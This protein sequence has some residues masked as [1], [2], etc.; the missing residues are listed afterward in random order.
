MSLNNLINELKNEA[1][2]EIVSLEKESSLRLQEIDQKGEQEVN[3]L[4]KEKEEDFSLEKKKTLD[5]YLK[6][7]EFQAQMDLLELK[8]KI[9]E[10]VIDKTK[11]KAKSF[12]VVGKK[13]IFKK[14]LEKIEKLI[15]NESFVYLPLGS[16]NIL[17][18][19][20]QKFD[21]QKIIEKDILEL[22]TVL[23]LRERNL[24]LRLTWKN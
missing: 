15:D 21:D 11:E 9:A 8:N 7:K 14:E 6:E 24:F 5:N 23:L 1:Q 19:L 12:E 17:K 3:L 13:E 16:K 22:R 4:N 2:K 20:F 18:D 10:K